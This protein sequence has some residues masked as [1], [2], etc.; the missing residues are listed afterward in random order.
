M[1][2][3][4]GGGWWRVM[5]GG[6]SDEEGRE[7]WRVRVEGMVGRGEGVGSNGM[8]REWSDGRGREWS[9]GEQWN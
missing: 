2:K 4:E 9:E 1:L 6:E 3:G 8:G 5:K 7:W